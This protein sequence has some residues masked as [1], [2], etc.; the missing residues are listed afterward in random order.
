[1]TRSLALSLVL[2]S[3]ALACASD[4]PPPAQSP[5]PMA[6][7]Q[8]GGPAAPRSAVAPGQD[9]K[10]SNVNISEAIRKACGITETEAFFAFNSSNVRAQ[11]KAVL[12][13]LATCFTSGPL[14]GRLMRVVG[15]ADPRGEDEYN[16]VLGEKRA[17]NVKA[18][19]GRE[20]LDLA[21]ME[22]T[23]RGEMDANGTDEGSWEK[24]RRVD[25][26]LGD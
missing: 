26:V 14:K 16:M 7:A 18:A 20:G 19:I 25:I 4:P 9:P 23:S 2:S 8:V 22:T 11:D 3:I 15:H 17:S 1:M 13:K 6:P 10:Q 21:K 12:G 5:M 24:D